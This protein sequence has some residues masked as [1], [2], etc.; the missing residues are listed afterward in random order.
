MYKLWPNLYTIRGV[1]YRDVSLW[2]ESIET[3]RELQA[4]YLVLSHTYPVIG[5]ENV[6]EVL[7]ITHD[8]IQYIYDQ[9]V[10]GINKGMTPNELVQTIKLP[11]TRE[12]VSLYSK[13]C[14][15]LSGWKFLPRVLRR[16]SAIRANAQ[17]L[18]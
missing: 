2:F 10:R 8:G 7:L 9:T 14:S 5:K 16:I 3:M 4:E 15:T 12:T 6:N 13:I 11:A 17:P 1:L 18:T